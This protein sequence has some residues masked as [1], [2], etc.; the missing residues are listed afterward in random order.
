MFF[1]E[2]RNIY[3]NGSLQTLNLD[4][5]NTLSVLEHY[6]YNNNSLRNGRLEADNKFSPYR[7]KIY[8]KSE[9]S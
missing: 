7:G 4:N 6:R 5:V 1:L 3:I 2:N 9:T 8:E